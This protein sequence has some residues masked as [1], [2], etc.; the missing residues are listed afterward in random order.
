MMPRFDLFIAPLRHLPCWSTCRNP[1]F[2]IPAVRRNHAR[3]SP[4]FNLNAHS[5]P[6]AGECRSKHLV[7]RLPYESRNM[8]NQ[9]DRVTAEHL[10]MFRPHRNCPPFVMFVVMK[11]WP[12]MYAQRPSTRKEQGPRDC[13]N[14]AVNRFAETPYALSKASQSKILSRFFKNPARS[15]RV[16]L[17]QCGFSI[18]GR[19]RKV[20]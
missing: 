2:P 7:T 6:S 3:R 13:G 12:P 5:P 20:V 8:A 18:G 4:E 17:R 10:K 16:L 9:R 14:N 15:C 1:T 11:K 19:L